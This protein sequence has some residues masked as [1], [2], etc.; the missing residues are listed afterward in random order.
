MEFT[1]EG[2]LVLYASPVTG[3]QIVGS[4]AKKI[5]RSVNNKDEEREKREDAGES[6]LVSPVSSL[7]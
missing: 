2:S 5:V 1:R 7:F 4:S 6:C 3:V